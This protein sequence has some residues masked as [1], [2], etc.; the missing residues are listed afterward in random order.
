MSNVKQFDMNNWD[1]EVLKSDSPVLVDFWAP[2]CGPCK[3]IGPVIE[4]LRD[5]SELTML[6]LEDNAIGSLDALR[7]L[8]K[9]RVLD[10]SALLGEAIR[11]IHNEESVS[12]LFI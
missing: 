9:L 7:G 8:A 1:Q 10:V 12:N 6:E 3:M 5:L 2:W 11:R 4:A